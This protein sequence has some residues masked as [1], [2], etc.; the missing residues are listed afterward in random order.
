[1]SYAYLKER[2]AEE[3]KAVV[4]SIGGIQ[5][6]ATAASKPV[7]TASKLTTTAM[8]KSVCLVFILIGFCLSIYCAAA[9]SLYKFFK[10]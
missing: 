6:S 7:V 8:V 1:M 10:K 3:H 4:V 5:R 9:Y 2:K